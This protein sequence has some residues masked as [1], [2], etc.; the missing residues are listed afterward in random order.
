MGEKVGQRL[1][2]QST[3]VVADAARRALEQEGPHVTQAVLA[4]PVVDHPLG[5]VAV[6]GRVAVDQVDP[7]GDVDRL[8]G[9]DAQ[10]GVAQEVHGQVQRRRG[11]LLVGHR[12]DVVRTGR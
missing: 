3:E 6:G 11:A 8:F 10:V 9:A 2:E 12:L 4:G 5:R 7:S 1:L